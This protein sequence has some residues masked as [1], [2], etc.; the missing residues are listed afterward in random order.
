MLSFSEK[1]YTDAITALAGVIQ[2]YGWDS[3]LGLLIARAYKILDKD[4]ESAI[5]YDRFIARTPRYAA[6]PELLWRRAWMEE[7][8][9][10]SLSAMNF[11]RRIGKSFPR[12]S[13]AD[14]SWVRRAL[15]Y[16]RVEHYDSA[17]GLLAEFEMK[18]PDSPF[19]PAARYWKARSLLG[20]EQ[21]DSAK[22]RFVEC[23]RREP[24][25]FYA[26]RSRSML[27]L[28]GDSVNSCLTIDT[29]ADIG[30]AIRWLDSVAPP[31]QKA[32]AADDRLALRRGLLLAAAGMVDEGEMF[33]ESVEL[34]YPGNLSLN[35]RTAAFYRS[36]GAVMQA[37]RS[38]R[39]LCWR[40]PAES[41]EHIPLP[42]FM[43]MYPFYYNDII[44][45]EALRRNVDP[46]FVR[47]VIRQESIFNA[48][49]VSPVGAIGLMQLMP[50]TGAACARELGER[51]CVDT[52]YKP[53]ANIRYGTFYLRKLLDQFKENEVLALA[54]YNGG[55]PN[56]REWYSRNRE[57][58]FDLFVEDIDFS[59]TRNYVKKV[60]A[61]YWIYKKLSDIGSCL[62]NH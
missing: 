19:L 12:C 40:I 14:E 22:M 25:E 58:D 61:N 1:K 51:F 24:A 32:L 15:C 47:A 55:P 7:E 54:S 33:L 8:Q 10:R 56:A 52:L 50:A 18:N 38:G 53:A 13:R 3:D 31:S 41:R 44:K 21:V 2:Q 26:H 42:V 46:S 9:G 48:D 28:L 49:A 23:A 45:S 16:Y 20:L 37:S 34:S 17:F 60:L 11:Y 27:A 39:R 43:A 5:W 30:R 29:I 59:E 6:L 62:S 36:I 35:F 4:K 57:K